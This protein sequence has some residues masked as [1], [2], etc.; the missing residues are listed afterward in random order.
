MIWNPSVP[1]FYSQDDSNK[2]WEMVNDYINIG[3][4][5]CIEVGERNMN[6]A[7]YVVLDACGLNVMPRVWAE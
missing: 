2:E 6:S 1:F 4:V 7:Q 3:Y 5:S